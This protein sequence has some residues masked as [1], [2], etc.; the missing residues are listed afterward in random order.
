MR[1]FPVLFGAASC[2]LVL[3]VSPVAQAAPPDNHFTETGFFVDRNFCGT[4]ESVRV[5]FSVKGT[6]HDSGAGT[7]FVTVHGTETYTARSTGKTVL[8]HFA[9]RVTDEFIEN[10]D[11]TFTLRTTYKGLAEQFRVKG[12]GVI[13]R[14]AGTIT[15]SLTIDE[16]GEVISED[17]TFRGPHPEAESGFTLFC[18]LLP[19]A[20]GIA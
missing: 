2:V 17:V 13:T 12:E 20:L 10:D 3:G 8:G 5:D 15:I 11:G 9:N 6:F 14:D 7:G 18:E 1:R 16:N 4:D 19:E